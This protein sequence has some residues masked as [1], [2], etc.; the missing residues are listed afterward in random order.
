MRTKSYKKLMIVPGYACNNRCIF[1]INYDMRTMPE[2]ST[3]ELLRRLKKGRADGCDYLEFAGGEDAIRKDFCLLVNAARKMGYE[4]I[5]VATNGRIFSYPDFAKRA[6]ESGLT[7][8]IFSIHASSEKIHDQLTQVSGCFRQALAG[9]ENI[10]ALFRSVKNT[11]VGTNTAITKLNYKELPN[12]GKF[13]LNSLGLCNAEFIFADPSRGGVARHFDM[14]MPKISDAAPYMRECLYLG[15]EHFRRGIVENLISNWAARYVPLCYFTDFFPFQISDVRENIVFNHVTHST[16]EGATPDYLKSR[17][18][19][20]RRKTLRCEACLLR[21]DCEGLW[22]RYLEEF[23]D[24]ELNP[25]KDPS[26]RERKI[27]YIKDFLSC[28]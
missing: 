14:L 13:I 8:I 27:K 24:S 5:A 6:V 19:V 21:E 22:H 1:C 16:P 25:V 2:R 28:R 15:Q 4:R 9:I 20:S 23:G 18:E 17:R 12:I 10:L 3:A 26:I 11:T 7:D